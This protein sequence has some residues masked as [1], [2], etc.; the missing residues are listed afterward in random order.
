MVIDAIVRAVGLGDVAGRR[1]TYCHLP[2]QGIKSS[3]GVL[4]DV[5]EVG[6]HE[7]EVRSFKFSLDQMPGEAQCLRRSR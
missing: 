4:C 7:Y 5:F 1:I 6:K 2:I 3:G